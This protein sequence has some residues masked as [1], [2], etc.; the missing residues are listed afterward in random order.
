[1]SER[2]V[3]FHPSPRTPATIFRDTAGL[4]ERSAGYRFDIE[5]REQGWHIHYAVDADTLVTYVSPSRNL[6][7]GGLFC[8]DENL[9]KLVVRMIGDFLVRE[10]MSGSPIPESRGRLLIVSPHDEEIQ[11]YLFRLQSDLHQRAHLGPEKADS[12]LQWI[13]SN[14]SHQEVAAA[15]LKH[16][17]EFMEAIGGTDGPAQAIHRFRDLNPSRVVNLLRYEHRKPDGSVFRFPRPP[18]DARDEGFSAFSDRYRVWKEALTDVNPEKP[19]RAIRTDAMVLATLE[20]VNEHIAEQSARVVLV[21]GTQNI[22]EAA[23]RLYPGRPSGSTFE[24]RYLRHPQAFLSDDGFFAA[25]EQA[26][27]THRKPFRVLDWLNTLLP[28]YV[29]PQ[30]SGAVRS[31][32]ISAELP[33]PEQLDGAVQAAPDFERRNLERELPELIQQWSDQVRNIAVKRGI[34][35]GLE[36]PRSAGG[37]VIAQLRESI[38]PGWTVEDLR[39]YLT[40]RARESLITLYRSSALL[41]VIAVRHEQN[42]IRGVPALRIDS[43]HELARTICRRMQLLMFRGEAELDLQELYYDLAKDD[44]GVYHALLIH[45]FAYAIRGHWYAARSFCRIALEFV[46]ESYSSGGTQPGENASPPVT[47]REAAYLLAVSQRRVAREPSEYQESERYL[48]NAVKRAP[49]H[50]KNDPRFRSEEIAGRVSLLLHRRLNAVGGSTGSFVAAV[51]LERELPAAQEILRSLVHEMLPEVVAWVTRQVF[52]NISS[53]AL[54]AEYDRSGSTAAS[55]SAL[56]SLIERF[57]ST[58]LAPDIPGHSRDELTDFLYW[59]MLVV[60]GAREGGDVE[61]RK[62]VMGVHPED[63]EQDA[64][65]VRTIQQLCRDRH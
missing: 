39:R 59:A 32:D 51:A 65:R 7:H 48:D 13:Q 28:K 33:T 5:Q 3:T 46:D 17:G 2:D 63:F 47:G 11:R 25:P 49:A 16:A 53:L 21:T 30:L 23:A 8:A 50:L 40:T 57:H 19:E 4:L 34:E 27:D 37:R 60:F 42:R 44:P 18:A 29:G 64:S 41:G 26:T 12:I 36:N 1:M 62:Q 10:L 20:W 43:Y 58:R 54:L 55:R 9:A 52:T 31:G 6:R 38:R 45:G 14:L 35:I 15:L 61:P 22:F 24:G 56:V